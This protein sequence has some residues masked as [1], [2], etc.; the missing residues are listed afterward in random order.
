MHQDH[1]DPTDLGRLTMFALGF[2]RLKAIAGGE[3]A[4]ARGSD[5]ASKPANMETRA[6]ADRKGRCGGPISR[7]T[8]AMLKR[9]DWLLA[10]CG[11]WHQCLSRRLPSR[12][13]DSAPSPASLAVQAMPPPSKVPAKIGIASLGA[14]QKAEV[15]GRAKRFQGDPESVLRRNRRASRLD[16][17]PAQAQAARETPHCNKLDRVTLT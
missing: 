5:S 6:A 4:R 9:L 1:D 2:P 16:A 15:H 17:S 11:A 12:P 14:P 3:Y 13:V 7:T 8:R 10:L